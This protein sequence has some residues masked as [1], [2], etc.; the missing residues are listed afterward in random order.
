MSMAS[1]RLSVTGFFNKLK[2]AIANVTLGQGPGTSRAS[3][4]SRRAA[5]T[6]NARMSTG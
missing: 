3:V 1:I 4:L 6:A 5:P 2:N